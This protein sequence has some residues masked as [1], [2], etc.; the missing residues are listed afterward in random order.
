MDGMGDAYDLP[1][2]DGMYIGYEFSWS[3]RCSF[4]IC[5]CQASTGDYVIGAKSG[6]R[7]L[8]D[9]MRV[10]QLVP[11]SG[12]GPMGFRWSLLYTKAE[13]SIICELK[14]TKQWQARLANGYKYVKARHG[15]NMTSLFTT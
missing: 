14:I 4:P 11:E 1:T 13:Q 12:H 2:W 15:R 10:P 8:M 7:L 6:K 3:S 5:A 9:A